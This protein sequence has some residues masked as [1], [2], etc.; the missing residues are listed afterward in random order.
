[1]NEEIQF[2]NYHEEHEMFYTKPVVVKPEPYL[3]INTLMLIL[4]DKPTEL[5][6]IIACKAMDSLV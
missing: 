5:G 6:T 3:Y 1:M 2:I 4:Q